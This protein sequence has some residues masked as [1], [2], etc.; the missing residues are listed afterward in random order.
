MLEIRGLSDEL[1]GLSITPAKIIRFRGKLSDSYSVTQH[2]LLLGVVFFLC[3]NNNET[4]T[5]AT[6]GSGSLSVC[7]ARWGWHAGT[8]P[9]S[10]TRQ[11]SYVCFIPVSEGRKGGK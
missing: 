7:R 3:I 11:M 2:S 9:C 5:S 8:V 10:D 4:H 6:Q 1:I